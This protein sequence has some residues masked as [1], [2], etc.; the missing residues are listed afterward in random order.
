MEIPINDRTAIRIFFMAKYYFFI[1]S[2]R[3]LSSVLSLL[4]KGPGAVLQPP[5]PLPSRERTR[6]RTTRITVVTRVSDMRC[7]PEFS[8]WMLIGDVFVIETLSYL[9][10][11]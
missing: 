10:I 8:L 5:R 6:K 9:L 11:A 3:E 2:S 1:F 4:Q 7:T